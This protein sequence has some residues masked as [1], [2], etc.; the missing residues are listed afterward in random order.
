MFALTKRSPARTSN[1]KINDANRMIQLYQTITQKKMKDSYEMRNSS[2]NNHHQRPPSQKSP[3]HFDKR[4]TIN[5]SSSR[6][7]TN[8]SS[9]ASLHQNQL[10]S[11]NHS[12]RNTAINGALNTT[13]STIRSRNQSP[14]NI[15]PQGPA[16]PKLFEPILGGNKK[17]QN[18]IIKLHKCIESQKI[19]K[20]SNYN[21]ENAPP[22]AAKHQRPHPNPNKPMR[23]KSLKNKD[24]HEPIQEVEDETVIKQSLILTNND[25][26]QS[27]CFQKKYLPN[28]FWP[29]KEL[30]ELVNATKNNTGSINGRREDNTNSGVFNTILNSTINNN[31]VDDELYDDIP[32]VQHIYKK[33]VSE[34][35]KHQATKKVL[36]KAIGLATMLLKEIQ[37]LELKQQ[38]LSPQRVSYQNPLIMSVDTMKS[39]DPNLLL[40]KRASI[41]DDMKE[42]HALT[43]MVMKENDSVQNQ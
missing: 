14:L 1:D 16:H 7:Q 21:D 37:T 4:N 13:N 29:Q 43:M 34:K 30:Q 19:S 20:C 42:I 35:Q 40:S 38:M 25:D 6:Y 26:M 33:Y 12:G 17:Y 3:P 9:T 27:K 41:R 36:D 39:F 8:C 23:Q 2:L 15:K 24:D 5:T 22:D 10:N 18:Q 11:L 32:T 28:G 31:S